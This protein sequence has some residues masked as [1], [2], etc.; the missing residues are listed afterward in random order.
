MAEIPRISGLG[1]LT[2]IIDDRSELQKG[3]QIF[4]GQGLK[5]LS[6]FESRLFAD[7]AGS[8]ASPYK[9]SLTFGEKKNEVKARCSCMAARSRPFCKHA[10][11]L[12][13]AWSKQPEG[14]VTAD[15]P[16]QPASSGG[17]AKKTVKKGKTETA[18]LM[19]TG[20][21][22]VSTLIRE[23]AL[24]GVASVS[25]ERPEQVRALGE[26]LRAN[27]L[28]RLSA[29]TLELAALLDKAA[30][31]TGVFEATA[32][33]ELL[34][35]MLL[36][37][38]KIEKH[39]GGEVMEKQ[40]V[41]E[42]IGKTWTKKDRAPV[43]DL[44]LVEYAFRT[45]TTP[46]NFIIRE[47]RFVDLGSGTHYAEKQIIPAFLRRVEPKKSYSGKVLLVSEGGLYPGFAPHRLDLE[48]VTE[49][50]V[51]GE[52]LE[53]FLEVAVPNVGAALAAFQEHR[54]DVFAPDRLPIL[55]K[56][57]TLLAAG[58]RSQFVDGKDH[59]LFLPA[60]P[61]LEEPLTAALQGGK[62]RAV[63]GDIGLEAALPTLFPVAV[64]VET[65]DGLEL[66]SFSLADEE[67]AATPRRRRASTPE[68]VRAPE[69][70]GVSWS[71]AAR[72][73]GASRA[74]IALA[75]VRDELAEHFANGLPSFTH[76]TVEPL[77]ARLTELTLQKPGALLLATAA[78][79]DAAE[80]LDDVV[81]LYQVLGIALVRLA[82]AVQ[83]ERGTLEPVA[84]HPSV[85]VRK[86]SPPLAPGEVLRR[87]ANGELTR[88]E[89]ASHYAHH[90]AQFGAEELLREIYPSW[91]D[92]SASEFVARAAAAHGRLAIEAAKNALQPFHGRMVRRTALRVLAQVGGVEA[93]GV[94]EEVRLGDKD[95]GMRV[96]A[97]ELLEDLQAKAKGPDAL[98]LV[99]RWRRERV[100]GQGRR[101][102]SAPN[103]DDRLLALGELERSGSSGCFSALRQVLY[104]DPVR[105]VRR[106][107][108]QIL[109]WLGDADVLDRFVQLIELRDEYDADAKDAAYA[110]GTLGDVRGVEALLDAFVAGWKPTVVSEALK[111]MGLAVLRPAVELAETRPEVLE[112]KAMT[113]LFE[114][115]HPQEVS[116]VVL[117]RLRAQQDAPEIAARCAVWLKIAA[118]HTV[119]EKLIGAAVLEIPAALADKAVSRAAKRAVK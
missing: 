62:L 27:G 104:G 12:L 53:K 41:E 101:A 30:E 55:V 5:N 31:R 43:S 112:R 48:S 42:L 60:Q 89:A 51:D 74:A 9:V 73:A 61:G 20:V 17:A 37:A 29:R 66:R 15:A 68:P 2:E 97:A 4:D 63:A 67:L 35:D 26:A 115:M 6:R 14:F 96:F 77:A 92:G 114:S 64:V 116:G 71:D 87:R 33:T 85:Q 102:I 54:K 57:D 46:D 52:L 80:R 36:T 105:E 58:A 34:T 13:V 100:A 79:A 93:R 44:S 56:V 111:S 103:K 70:S 24:S 45:Q 10:A 113:S 88:F 98:R 90:Y 106:R 78:R 49:G 99:R 22:Q 81:K 119:S 25:A 8:G 23:L 108:A 91:A 38:R 47:S 107:A 65:E 94:L 18:D 32:Y 83:V 118:A 7:A 40:Y 69:A 86:P 19:R 109:A 95:A 110:L 21:E 59:A 39:L 76:R 50:D 84:S 3:A 75:E 82:G 72:A 117:A 28:R 16:P 11:A 1:G